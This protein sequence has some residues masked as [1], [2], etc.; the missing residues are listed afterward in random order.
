MNPSNSEQFFNAAT[1]PKIIVVMGVAGCGKSSVG[2]GLARSLE[3]PFLDAD[4]YHPASNVQKMSQGTPLTD[5]DR[6][7][8]LDSLGR[9]LASCASESGVSIAACSALRRAY[10]Q[11]LVAAARQEI[12]FVYLEGSRELIGTRMAARKDHF[13]PT[14]LLDSQFATLEPPGVD[15]NALVVNVEHSVAELVQTIIKQLKTG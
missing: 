1:V 2:Q 14:A 12:T 13:M 7:P 6:W 4:D 15:E 10:R 3:K 5:E 9:A 11:R 8:W